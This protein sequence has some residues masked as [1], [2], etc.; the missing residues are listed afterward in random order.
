MKKLKIKLK[1]SSTLVENFNIS[2]NFIKR[3]CLTNH[4][5]ILNIKM[6]ILPKITKRFTNLRSPHIYKKSKEQLCIQTYSGIINFSIYDSPNSF[7]HCKNMCFLLCKFLG[8]N[9]K[10]KI[11]IL[12]KNI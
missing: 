12:S 3:Y 2:K 11:E 4:F 1:L 7:N 9:T 10:M 8:T 5:Q 6:H